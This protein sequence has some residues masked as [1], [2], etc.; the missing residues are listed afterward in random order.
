MTNSGERTLDLEY[1]SKYVCM[2]VPVLGCTV[3]TRTKGGADIKNADVCSSELRV[4]VSIAFVVP[5]LQVFH[6]A[7]M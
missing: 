4:S 6:R 7:Y 1:L 2:G 3:H 5:M